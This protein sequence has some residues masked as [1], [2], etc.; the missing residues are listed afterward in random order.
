MNS[1]KFFFTTNLIYYSEEKNG[2]R[3]TPQ[4]MR[5]CVESRRFHISQIIMTMENFEAKPIH[6]FVALIYFMSVT[7]TKFI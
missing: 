6:D 4:L 7:F 5:K 2:Y 3:L 1:N